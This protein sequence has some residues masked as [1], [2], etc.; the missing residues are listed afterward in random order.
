MGPEGPSI[1]SATG[2]RLPLS[3]PAIQAGLQR[4]IE[5]LVRKRVKKFVALVPMVLAGGDADAVHDARVFSRRV[6]QAVN[7]LFPKPRMGKARQLYRVPRRVRRALGEWRNCD[8]LLDLVRR[9]LGRSRSETKRR[10]WEL[11]HAYLL[12]KRGEE[13]GRA[14]KKLLRQDPA[15]YADLAHR[16]LDHPPSDIADTIVGRLYAS[17]GDAWDSW[18]SA[19]TRASDT[20][21]VA[22]MHA[23]RVATK[24]LRYR[25][26]LVHDVGPERMKLELTWLAALQEALGAWHDRQLLQQAVAEAVGHADTLLN[27]LSRA[28][29]LLADLDAERRRPPKAVEHILGLAREHPGCAQMKRWVASH[30]GPASHPEPADAARQG[31][32]RRK[33][34]VPA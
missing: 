13:I 15:G 18:Q 30:S 12:E 27:D 8:V 7:A 3:C 22:D 28:R 21:A 23:L 17:V 5:R 16:L 33:D 1:E 10:A 34:E 19:L 2:G 6:Q 25:A 31:N 29:I 9:R 4:D 20:R 24:S 32:A 26:E 11:V 14:R